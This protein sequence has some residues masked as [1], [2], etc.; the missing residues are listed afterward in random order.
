MS[1]ITLPVLSKGFSALVLLS[2]ISFGT[3]AQI[4]F[5]NGAQIYTA[6]QSIVQVNGGIENNSSISNGLI[7]HNGTMTVTL[8]STFPNPGDVILNNNSTWKGNGKIFVEGDWNNNATF[9]QD[10]STVTMFASTVQQ[11]ITGTVP[12]TF[13]NLILTGT[14]VGPNR[15]KLQTL[16]ASV[17]SLLNVNDR[18]LATDVNT[19]F[20]LNPDPTIV[21]NNQT[22]GSEGFVSSLAPGTLSRVTGNPF[23]VAPYLY[24]V[25]SSVV[26]TRYRPVVITPN[27]NNA[28]AYTVR[29]INHDANVDGFNRSTND[30]IMCATIDTFYHAILR[31]GA[32]NTPADISV[33][34]KS[35][36]DGLWT[37]MAQW[38]TNN[39]MWNNMPSINPS[40]NSGFDVL[41]RPAWLFANPGDPY[42]LTNLRPAAPTI[43]CPTICE[44]GTGIFVA[45]NGNNYSWVVPNG[46]TIV[47]GQGTDS[48]TVNWGSNPGTVYVMDTTLGAACASL[49]DSCVTTPVP[50]PIAGF[51]TA[52]IGNFQTTYQFADTSTGGTTW[53]WDFG[54]GTTSNLENPSHQ[55]QG[56]GTYTVMQI[57]TNAAGCVDT[58]VSTVVVNEGIL[59][60]N[61]FTPDGDGINDEFY[62][63]SSGFESFSIEI[64]NR[65]GTKIWDA[66]S[67]QIRW[68]GHSTSGQM[69]SD[70]TY[71]FV[72]NA[73]LKS[74][75]G[76]KTYKQ[77]GFVELLATKHK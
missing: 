77:A 6:P 66:N 7:D 18:E 38:R 69:M 57:V 45:G 9:Q 24:P 33:Y 41:T 47:S 29:F 13:H 75:G 63:P 72:L 11:T 50:A 74:Q 59:I 52:S 65:W 26:L 55:Y 68:D 42:L 14:G 60:P 36:T 15:I 1:K 10:L 20:V 32:N 4:F 73:I 67:G 54:D 34:Y 58:I 70:G 37:G 17:D 64:F 16:D 46:T 28:D 51:D 56:A 3:R 53:F 30:G 22:P 43:V 23:S 48:L 19:M 12:T 25:G 62:I 2:C 40:T 61:V 35:G 5:N 44:N 39:N 49:P 27:N 76:N 71:Y 8:N 31:T 21:L